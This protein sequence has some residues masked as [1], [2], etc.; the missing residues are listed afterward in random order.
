MNPRHNTEERE[1]RRSNEGLGDAHGVES[2][3]V[4]EVEATAA[5]H[6]DSRESNRFAVGPS[7]HDSHDYQGELPRVRYGR[8]VV[9]AVKSDGL[10]RPSEVLRDRGL[11]CVDRSHDDLLLTLA[12]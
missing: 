4:E 8:R 3:G 6:E 2:T 5:I 11:D 1:L 12:L 7:P 10:L 9:L